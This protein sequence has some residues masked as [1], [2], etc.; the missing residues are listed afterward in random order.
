MFCFKNAVETIIGF[1]RI[2]PLKRK[3]RLLD[4]PAE[5]H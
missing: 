4:V 3:E 2:L 5:N 1:N